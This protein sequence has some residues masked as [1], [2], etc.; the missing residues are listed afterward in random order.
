MLDDAASN[1]T[2]I[3]TSIF[4][5]VMLDGYASI[6][7]STIVPYDPSLYAPDY[8]FPTEPL[9]QPEPQPFRT[10][11]PKCTGCK[12]K[13]AYLWLDGADKCN[14]CT[15]KGIECI[16]G[17]GRRKYRTRCASC[18]ALYLDCIRQKRYVN[19]ACGRDT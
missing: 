14:R 10:Q 11:H 16:S 3:I 18:R 4:I 2:R 15:F 1:Y 19:H 12:L 6:F 17:K 9:L 8:P 7:T 13:P 5:E